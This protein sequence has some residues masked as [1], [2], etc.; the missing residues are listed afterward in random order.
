M[1]NAILD[2]FEGNLFAALVTIAILVWVGSKA[3]AGRQNLRVWGWRIALIAFALYFVEAF[4]TKEAGESELFLSSGLI[5]L[6]IGGLALGT[7]WIVLS[8]ATFLLHELRGIVPSLFRLRREADERRRRE[9]ERLCARDEERRNAEEREKRELEKQRLQLAKVETEKVDK[10]R[11]EDARLR[12]QMLYDR[13]Q[14]ALA[15]HFSRERLHEYF[16]TFLTDTHPPDQVEERARLLEQLLH[17]ALE[18]ASRNGQKFHS[19]GEIAN[20]FRD[21]REDLVRAG[22]PEDVRDSLDTDI[23]EQE[24][25]A[26]REFLKP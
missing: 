15:H 20:Y 26:I 2:R 9:A 24:Q 6:V 8:I 1:M 22:Y 11:R 4:A 21:R 25:T 18:V 5:A 7:S 13:H 12:C 17:Q 10:K 16:Q 19:L 14:V 23:A 3:V